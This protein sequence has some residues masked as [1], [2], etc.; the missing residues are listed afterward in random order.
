MYPPSIPMGLRWDAY[1]L[2]AGP[3]GPLW[4]LHRQADRLEL[5]NFSATHKFLLAVDV[6]PFY[7]TWGLCKLS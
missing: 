4:A 2:C 6:F 1:E 7:E 5:Y 3:M